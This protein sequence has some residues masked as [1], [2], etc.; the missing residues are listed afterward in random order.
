MQHNEWNPPLNLQFCSGKRECG[1]QAA[2][3]STVGHFVGA[4]ILIV[5]HRDCRGICRA[6]PLRI[7]GGEVGK[8]LQQPVQG[9]WWT[10]FM[11]ASAQVLISLLALFICRTSLVHSDQG[12]QQ[13]AD[14]PE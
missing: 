3:S 4:P 11:P 8:D 2:S 7:C 5:P 9:S 14:L 6:Q 10:D 13:N 1:G 12:T